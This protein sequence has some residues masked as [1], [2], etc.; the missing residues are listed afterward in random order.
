MA[1]S[2]FNEDIDELDA[3]VFTNEYIDEDVNKMAD[4][5]IAAT[6]IATLARATAGDRR[7]SLRYRDLLT[8]YGMGHEMVAVLR[9]DGRCW[10]A[11]TLY[12]AEGSDDFSDDDLAWSVQPDQRWPKGRDAACSSGRRTRPT[13]PRPRP[14]APLLSSSSMP[15]SSSCR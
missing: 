9:A 12:R 5:A 15:P 7:H 6:G 1:T 10:G 11:L 14:V 13:S 8:A 4:L 3:E 2:H